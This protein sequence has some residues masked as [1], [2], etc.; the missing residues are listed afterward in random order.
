MDV[1]RAYDLCTHRL[2]DGKQVFNSQISY[3]QFCLRICT[4]VPPNS[5]V[6][7]MCEQ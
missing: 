5:T 7:L 4:A 3:D 2:L 6:D 1:F